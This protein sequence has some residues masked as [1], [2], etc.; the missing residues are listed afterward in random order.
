MTQIAWLG[1][2]SEMR[3]EIWFALTKK[4]FHVIWKNMTQKELKW[5]NFNKSMTE[6]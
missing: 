6:L 5:D 4:L 3:A 2:S 1:I